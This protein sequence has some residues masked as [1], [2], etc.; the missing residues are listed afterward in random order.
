MPRII[1]HILLE[2]KLKFTQQKDD[3]EMYSQDILELLFIFNKYINTILINMFLYFYYIYYA[4]FTFNMFIL[5][6]IF[7]NNDNLFWLF[8]FYFINI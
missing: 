1:G 5:I 3:R 2:W 6:D 7:L 4:P 8:L